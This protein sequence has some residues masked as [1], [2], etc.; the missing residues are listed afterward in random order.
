MT[1]RAAP[2]VATPGAAGGL[3]EAGDVVA[4]GQ[5]EEAFAAQ[6]A[7]PGLLQRGQQAPRVEGPA[8]S[9]GCQSQTLC[10]CVI[11]AASAH[12]HR[13]MPLSYITGV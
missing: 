6:H 5:P 1:A 2:G 8:C 10:R 12:R 9:S 4:R 13:R 3:P 7:G 11:A